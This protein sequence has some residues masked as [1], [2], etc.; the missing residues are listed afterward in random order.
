MPPAITLEIAKG[1]TLYIV[2]AVMNGRGD[3]LVDLAM[4]EPVA[5]ARGGLRWTSAL[6]LSRIEFAFTISFPHHFPVVHDR[7]GSVADGA[8]GPGA[9]DRETGLPHGLRVLA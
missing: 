5:L 1:F 8:G 9:G 2:Q 7:A 4:H 3:Q 6:L